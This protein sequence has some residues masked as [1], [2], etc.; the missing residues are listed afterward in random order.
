V[1]SEISGADNRGGSGSIRDRIDYPDRVGKDDV[2]RDGQI[3]ID[4]I[5]SSGDDNDTSS[6]V[7][8]SR[9]VLHPSTSYVPPDG[10]L[11]NNSTTVS[12]ITIIKLVVLKVERVF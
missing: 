1:L 3:P 8:D 5:D 10:G 6:R 12:F 11:V 9:G 4:R 7:K 2:I